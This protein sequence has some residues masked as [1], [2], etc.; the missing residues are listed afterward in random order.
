MSFSLLKRQGRMAIIN[1]RIV[2]LG[3]GF[4]GVYAAKYLS[5][6]LRRVGKTDV[7]VALVSRENYLVFQPLLPEII[8]GGLDTLQTISP[9]RRIAPNAVLHVRAVE[10]I[11][12]ANQVI[13]LEPGYMRRHLDLSFDH[14]VLAMGTQLAVD[15]VPGLQEHSLPFK[16]L[17]DALR[18][19][20]HLVHVLEEAAITQ[21]LDERRRL[22]SFVV[23]GG[24]FSGVECIAEMHDF[25]H[26]A[27]KAY[28]NIDEQDLRIVL[29]QSGDSILLEM[30]PKLAQFAHRL[31]VSRGIHIE[32]Q[33]RLSAVTAQAA[34]TFNKTT[35]EASS[36]STRTVVATV[37]VEPHPLLASLPLTHVK[38]KVAVTSQLCSAEMAN[39]WAIGDCAAITMND[40]SLAPPT[41]QHAVR[42]AKLCAQNIAATLTGKPM[43]PYTF[44]SLGSLASLGRHSAVA[45][46]L[47]LKVSGFLAWIMWRAIYFAK[48]PGWER[49]IRILAD[50][51]LDFV[52]PRDITQLRIFP[53]P[54]VRREHFEA[55]EILFRESDIGDRVYF[56]I[57]GEIE[58][59]VGGELVDAVGAGSVIGEVALVSNRPRTATA[60]AKGVVN[61]ASVDRDTFYTLVSHFPGV[62][63]AMDAV[64]GEHLSAD[65]RRLGSV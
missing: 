37:P 21:D 22:L 16:Y 14:L 29:L 28:P 27:V 60:C 65:R 56:V 11:D 34:H 15:K 59:F 31:L 52:L 41:A 26:H 33:T 61:V 54:S 44:K 43:K 57:D 2:I 13:Q 7:E 55:G 46:V 3:G 38:G 50:W 25:L 47:G 42:Q 51:T 9:I 63:E 23:A 4:A 49:K 1:Q 6:Q 19:R 8:A 17:G 35:K 64:M 39:I 18:L 53:P 48:F 20:H 36:I 10:K 40:G 5:Q 62:K 30:K 32:L 45:E 24:G 12:L 58:I